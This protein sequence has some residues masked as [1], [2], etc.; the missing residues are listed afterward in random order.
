MAKLT[1]RK[2]LVGNNVSHSMR[3]TKRRQNLNLQTKTVNGAKVTLTNREWK[4]LNKTDKACK[5]ET[6]EA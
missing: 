1:T 4:A 3:H 6:V 2:P 5:T